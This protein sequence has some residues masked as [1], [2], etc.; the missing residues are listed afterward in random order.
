MNDHTPK[1]LRGLA[2]L[3]C[4]AALASWPAQAASARVQGGEADLVDRIVAIVGDTVVL[5]TEV[6]EAVLRLQGQGAVVPTD[7]EEFD[8]FLAGVLEQK[9]NEVLIVLHAR[10]EG[11]TV[12]ETQVEEVV[13]EQLARIKRQF[14]SELEFQQ[15]LTEM[16]TTAAEF[17]L[18]LA[19]QARVELTAQKYLQLK[20]SGLKPVPVGEDE[21]RERYEAQKNLLGP[22]PATVSL[23]NILVTPKPSED[24]RLAAWNRAQEALSRAN[25]GEDFA[26]LAR[27][28]SD[29]TATR[30]QGGNLGWVRQGQLL[31]EFETTL[32]SMQVGEISDLVETSVGFHII[33]LERIRGADRQARHILIRPEM[34]DADVARA[35]DSA[36]DVAAALRAGADADSLARLHADP[37]E[38]S[39]LTDFPQDRLPPEYQQAL[40]GARPGDVVGPFSL[41]VPGVVGGKW[42]V[43][44][45]EDISPGGAW[46]YEDVKDRLRR[47][48][49]QDKM[50]GQVVDD[51]R[52]S[53]YIEVRLVN[54]TRVG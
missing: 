18:T 39:G 52:K 5:L 25:S 41:P 49:E 16:G 22:K 46:T 23:R 48:I 29:D 53:T 51:L 27:E 9:V 26:R 14:K 6:Q 19:E 47:Q 10:R 1:H 34:T 20:L 12:P 28:Y 33:K 15:A 35:R 42:A 44:V 3:L 21:I 2:T 36:E 37:E 11:I 17:R 4:L 45:V 43:I 13:E 30:G 38:S 50:L 54:E 7:P 31:P 24:A 40:Q 8:R 32:F